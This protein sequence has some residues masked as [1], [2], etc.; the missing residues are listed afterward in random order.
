MSKYL[1]GKIYKLHSYDNELIYIGSTIQILSQRYAGHK[2]NFKKNKN[3]T[4]KI[5][6]QNSDNVIITLIKL[7]PCHCKSELEAEERLYIQNVECVNKQIPTRTK[8]EY[9]L[10]NKDKIHKYYQDNKEHNKDKIQKYYQDNKEHIKTTRKQYYNN[11]KEYLRTNQKQYY[12]NNKN[13]L[14]LY[15][16]QY[17]EDNKEQIRHYK[18]WNHNKKLFNTIKPLFYD[19]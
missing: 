2:A 19:M 1:N 15:K 13:R 14:S 16:I 10:D 17:Y 8:K 9:R 12:N 5:L 18:Y 3:V 6:F 4:S 7:F 11:N